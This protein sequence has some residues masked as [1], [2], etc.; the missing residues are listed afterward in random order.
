MMILLGGRIK[1]ETICREETQ[2]RGQI[3]LMAVI[4]SVLANAT[5]RRREDSKIVMGERRED[6]E[7]MME[8][9]E[10]M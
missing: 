7:K 1:T 9:K 5:R 2:S 3:K 8:E 10:S 4:D 6:E